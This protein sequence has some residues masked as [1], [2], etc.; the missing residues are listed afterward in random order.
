MSVDKLVKDL[1]G[2]KSLDLSDLKK[3]LYIF[4]HGSFAKDCFKA[5][6]EEGISPKGF[7]VS[8]KSSD[9]NFDDVFSIDEIDISDSIVYLGVF[10][11]EHPYQDII[12]PL[13]AKG[14]KKIIMPWDVYKSLR[15]HIGQRF[16]LESPEYYQKNINNISKAVDMLADDES[17][18]MLKNIVRF[19]SGLMNEYSAF[20]SNDEQYFNKLT[21][22][23]KD[24]N[25][26]YVDGGAYDGDT[27]FECI[28]NINIFEAYLFEPDPNNLETLNK[29]CKAAD[30]KPAVIPLGLS[31]SY[32]TFTFS[33][34]GEGGHIDDEGEITIATCAMDEFFGDKKVDFIKLDIEG[35]EKNALLGAKNIIKNH[36]PIICL[37][38]YHKPEDI[39]DLANVINS[40]S[41]N[42]SFYLRQHLYNS[43]ELVL[44]AIPTS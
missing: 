38:A 11:R 40:I 39:W 41:N 19:R 3:D 20:K 22:N 17:K 18:E 7:I 29:N 42:Y 23:S 31:D 25:I 24:T 16:W 44:Y 37:S 30:I 10:N 1:N 26:T 13:E 27:Y 9:N 35:N 43:L 15:N 8:S 6:K 4:G 33:P 32:N 2:I 21:C 12:K 28:K 14:C 36:N 5:F 34:C